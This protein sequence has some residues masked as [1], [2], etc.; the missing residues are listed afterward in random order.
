M[1]IL[2]TK[3]IP[4]KTSMCNNIHY[5]L[6]TLCY[7]LLHYLK[8]MIITNMVITKIILPYASMAILLI[9]LSAFYT[10]YLITLMFTSFKFNAKCNKVAI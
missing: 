6:K 10:T 3:N 1:A 5:A 2:A 9:F 4:K 7:I 8:E